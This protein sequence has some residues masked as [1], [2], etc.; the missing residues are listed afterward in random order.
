VRFPPAALSFIAVMVQ[1]QNA[2]MPASRSG[3]DSRSPLQPNAGGDYMVRTA[4]SIGFK[5]RRGRASVRASPPILSALF[6]QR[7]SWG[8]HVASSILVS[9]S[10]C[11]AVAQWKST[12]SAPLVAALA[13]FPERGRLPCKEDVAG[14]TPAGGSEANDREDYTRPLIGAERH[15]SSHRLSPP[16]AE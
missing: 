16:I 11:A 1:Q 15:V 3:C 4:R 13:V 6:M 10:S 12:V 14:A 7:M 5:S 2:R 9:G 8:L